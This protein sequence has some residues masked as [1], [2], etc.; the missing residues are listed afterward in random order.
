[1]LS[2]SGS[3]A[4]HR[5]PALDLHQRAVLVLAQ[6]DLLRLQLRQPVEQPRIAGATC[7]RTGSVLMNS[8]T[9]VSTPGRSGG[10]P[11]DRRAEDA[12]R[13]VPL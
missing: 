11:G 4:R 1:M 5:A 10:R 13:R 7:T 6:L 2:N 8:P 9:I 12:H 3:A